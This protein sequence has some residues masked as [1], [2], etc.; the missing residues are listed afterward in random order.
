M[1][2]GVRGMIDRLRKLVQKYQD[3]VI[4]GGRELL[5]EC[6]LEELRA[7]SKAYEVEVTYGY[8]AEEILTT[9][10]F[11]NRME[12]FYQYYKE[13]VLQ[14]E[15]VKPSAAHD[16]IAQ[17]GQNNKQLG[18]ITR[19][20]YGLYQLAGVK[21]IIELHGTIHKNTCVKC[22]KNYSAEYVKNTKGVPVC[23]ECNLPLRPGIAFFE[24][25]LD[26]G[27]LSKSVEMVMQAEVLI[28]AGD[29]VDCPLCKMLLPYYEGN[30]LVVINQ[31][32][33]FC[34]QIANDLLTGS[35]QEI[36][37]QLVQR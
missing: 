33:Q 5:Y 15:R 29:H 9:R 20:V 30:R 19:D 1:G 12:L 36:L 24:E 27:L 25:A 13:H 34:D 8:S 3:I 32:N 28:V 11:R 18:V 17:L 4:L 10:F 14:L 22:G 35:C 31:T 6:G 37:P 21:N 23:A 16:A 26:N 7:E 2:K